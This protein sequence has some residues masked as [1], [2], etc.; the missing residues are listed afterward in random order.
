[1]VLPVPDKFADEGGIFLVEVE[2]FALI[3][4]R[5]THRVGVFALHERLHLVAFEI[6]VQPLLADVFDEFVTAIHPTRNVAPLA[7]AFVVGQS[8][9][10]EFF[11]GGHYALE[12]VAVATLVAC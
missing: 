3:T 8:G 2:H 1:M 11:D 10:V 6:V 4:H 9:F 7:V 5:I 12:I